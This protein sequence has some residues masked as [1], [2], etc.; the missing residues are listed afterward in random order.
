[1]KTF[2]LFGKY[3]LDQV[4]NLTAGQNRQ[5]DDLVKKM[6]GQL[7][8]YNALMNRNEL[9]LNVELPKEKTA[10]KLNSAL[11]SLLGLKFCWELATPIEASLRPSCNFEM[12]TAKLS[13][14]SLTSEASGRF[15][16]Q[17]SRPS[18]SVLFE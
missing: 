3:H 6:G 8:S 5:I 7:I 15:V 12:W 9:L 14:R 17:R 13:K 18:A 4:C 2:F 10:V 1:M 11:E 16:R